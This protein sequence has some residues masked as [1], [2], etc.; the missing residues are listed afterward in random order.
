[1]EKLYTSS[2]PPEHDENFGIENNEQNYTEPQDFAPADI[3]EIENYANENGLSQ[4]DTA[5]TIAELDQKTREEKNEEPGDQLTALAGDIESIEEK[6]DGIEAGL[7]GAVGELYE[8][9]N[10]LSGFFG[11]LS[12]FLKELEYYLSRIANETDP[13]EKKRLTA[14]LQAKINSFGR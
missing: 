13:D 6:L 2:T 7:G 5:A 11:E 10:T 8:L 3:Q 1:M 9:Q 14:E 4:E 12:H